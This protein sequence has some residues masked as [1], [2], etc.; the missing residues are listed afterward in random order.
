MKKYFLIT[1]TAIIMATGNSNAQSSLLATLSHEGQIT[2]FQGSMA[3]KEAMMAASHGDNITLSSGDFNAV[4][5]EK[6]ITLRGFG[7]QEDAIK[8]TLPTRIVGNFKINIPSD[9]TSKFSIEGIYNTE[10][11][12]FN[13]SLNYPTIQKC[14]FKEIN[15]A[16]C[17]FNSMT[18]IHC[19]ITESISLNNSSTVRFVNSCIRYPTFPSYSAT[20]AL[21]F[22][23]CFLL[24]AYNAYHSVSTNCIFDFSKDDL[25]LPESHTCYSCISFGK[26]FSE[27]SQISNTT[28][29]NREALHNLFKKDTFYELT[30]E[31]K[32]NYLGN[33]GTEIGIYGG[34]MPFSPRILIPQITKCDVSAKTTVD[35]KLSVDIEVKAAE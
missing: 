29:Q 16:K 21:D 31:A 18:V 5:I 28:L 14:S 8:G 3:L 20:G 2:I 13:G 7:M 17:V 10:L 34:N 15:A 26:A 24:N 11:V 33:D 19:K 23:N 6:A 30:D 22:T 32:S 35:G 9:V 25:T 27:V 4:D 12:T 1:L